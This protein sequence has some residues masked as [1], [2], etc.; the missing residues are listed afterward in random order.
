M[1]I[2][3]IKSRLLNNLAL[4]LLIQDYIDSVYLQVF[5]SALLWVII[6]LV[7]MTFIFKYQESTWTYEQSVYFSFITMTTIGFGDF[8][9]AQV[10]NCSDVVE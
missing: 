3:R 6:L 2:I 5:V 4:L 1:L 8:V 7:L 9:P 10:G